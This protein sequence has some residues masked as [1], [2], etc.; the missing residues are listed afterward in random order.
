VACPY[1]KQ[2]QSESIIR[3]P[4]DDPEIIRLMLDFLYTLDYD[5]HDDSDTE[6]A[7]SASLWFAWAE[8]D[9]LSRSDRRKLQEGL[10][11]MNGDAM[12]KAILVTNEKYPDVK[13]GSSKLKINTC[14]H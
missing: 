3:L 9:S 10:F 12:S 6:E 11:R 13:V 5:A 8:R 7:H 1:A 2:E 4:E 14:N